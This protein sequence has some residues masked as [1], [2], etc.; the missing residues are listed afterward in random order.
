MLFRSDVIISMYGI[1]PYRFSPPTVLVSYPQFSIK[2]RVVPGITQPITKGTRQV[3]TSRSP[4]RISRGLS[5][6]VARDLGSRLC[7]RCR[8]RNSVGDVCSHHKPRGCVVPRVCSRLPQ[9]RCAFAVSFRRKHFGGAYH[10]PF[11]AWRLCSEGLWKG[12]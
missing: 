9:A 10:S 1:I 4:C 11:Q 5:A 3:S 2:V 8:S 7:C 6:H 12:S